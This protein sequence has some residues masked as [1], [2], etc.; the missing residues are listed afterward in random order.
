MIPEAEVVVIGGGVHGASVAYHL[1]KAGR[2]V[3]LLER[4][5]VGAGSSGASGGIIRCHYSNPPMVRLAHRAAQLWPRLADEL[6]SPVDYV[7]NGFVATVGAADAASMR[8]VVEMQRQVGVDAELI[9]PE[10]VR[11][12]IPGFAHDGLALAA[13]EAEAGYADPYSTAAAFAN[14][15]RELGAAIY[16]G[17]AVVDIMR[18]GAVSGVATDHGSIRT[19]LV[20]NCAGA[21]APQIARMAGVTLPIKP[22]LLQMVAFN[23]RHGGWTPTSPTWIDI[24]T[25]TYCR[26]DA[27]GLMLA[28]GGSAENAE[29]E[30]DA[31]DL[32]TDPPRPSMMFE[33]EIHDNLVR[34]CPWAERMSRVRSWS[35]PD[36]ISP[37]FHLI[38]GPV[39]GVRGYLQVVGGSGNSFK[40]CPATGE[41]V[42]E[43]VT[44]GRCS[45]VDLEAFSITRFAEHR[46]FRGGYRMHITG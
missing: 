10:E 7:R 33:A 13:Y 43:Y 45:Y 18:N 27:M 35:G 30:T 39:P 4:R 38:F 29:L 24:T 36:G 28:G 8:R 37:D 20:V 5:T 25:M 44:T 26:P 17:V 31:P 46:E 15:A 34:R 32:D 23:P 19:P 3:A 9:E 40:L 14:A 1:A 12:W 42:A 6:G 21:W 11:R 16:P 22:G 2:Q 41:A